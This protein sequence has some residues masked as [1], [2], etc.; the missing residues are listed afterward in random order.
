[1]IC[2][3]EDGSRGFSCSSTNGKCSKKIAR[4]RGPNNIGGRTERMD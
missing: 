2:S 4:T 3:Q 1:M